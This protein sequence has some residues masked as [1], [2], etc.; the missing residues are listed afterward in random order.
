MEDQI[1][2]EHFRLSEFTN[3]ATA[4]ANGIDNSVPNRFIPSIVNLCNQ[5][6]EPLRQQVNEPVIISSGY[7]S[8]ELNRLVG[9]VPNSQHLTGEAADIYVADNAKLRE[10]YRLLADGIFDQLVLEKSG[11]KTWIHVSCKQDLSKNRQR[12]FKVQR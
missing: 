10:W 4:I 1:L 5:V 7:R 8:P 3:S 6:L 9:G 2:T 11:S 12:I